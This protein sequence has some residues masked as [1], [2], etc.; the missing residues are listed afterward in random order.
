MS[1]L[2]RLNHDV[3]TWIGQSPRIVADEE[4]QF[5]LDVANFSIGERD[6]REYTCVREQRFQMPRDRFR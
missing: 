4:L 1:S 6:K 2:L 5:A 3:Q